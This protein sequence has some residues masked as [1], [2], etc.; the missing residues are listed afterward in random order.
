MNNQMHGFVAAENAPLHD[1]DLARSSGAANLIDNCLGNVEGM[2]I[3]LVCE[4]PRHGWYDSAA[5]DR[6]HRELLARGA[7]VRRMMVDL[8]ENRPNADVQAAMNEVD[9]VIFFSRLGDQGRFN[10]HY[11]G[12]LCVMSYA[13]NE[14]MLEGGYGSLDHLSMHR[15]KTA[16]DEVT[17]GAENIR[18]T[19]PLGTYFEG[20][21]SATATSGSDVVIHRFPMGI[22]QPVLAEGFSGKAV[23]SHYLTPTGSRIYT[24]EYLP[25]RDPVTAHFEAS[26]IT[27]FSGPADL[28]AA[29]EA[30]YERVAR[31]FG[32]DGYNIDSWHAGIHPL[33]SYD[34]PAALDPLRWSGTAFQHPRLLHFHTCGS[35][36]PGEICWMILDPTIEVDGI[37][38][39]ERGQLHPERFAATRR[40]LDGDPALAAA[41]RAPAGP[42][43]VEPAP[44]APAFSPAASTPAGSF[45]ADSFPADPATSSQ[46]A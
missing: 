3:L 13:L 39:W 20:S 25:L 4:D 7:A 30:H 28:V 45:P 33:M 46:G 42:V 18:V 44:A 9:R 29:V 15:L 2:T 12:P 37:A 40:V 10:W 26:R 24:P 22:P 1:M 41:F 31:D 11:T 14:A 32:L 34:Q 19:C 16:I 21:P 35:G 38:L 27:G 8:P 5:P 36:P 17:L 23:L 43:G 6:V